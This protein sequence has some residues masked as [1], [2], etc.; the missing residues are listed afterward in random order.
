MK[1]YLLDMGK[2]GLEYLETIELRDYTDDDIKKLTNAFSVELIAPS[3]PFI[4]FERENI[5][6]LLSLS[7]CKRCGKC[8]LPDKT[9]P[10]NPG[11]IVGE[12]DLM[13]I[14]K[15]TKHSLKSLK[16]IV[17]LS[18]NPKYHAGALFL[19]LP[20]M[21]FNKNERSCKIYSHRPLICRIYPISDDS[22][23]DNVTIDV[24]CDYGKEI[25]QKALKL[26][27]DADR[28]RKKVV[29]GKSGELPVL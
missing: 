5:N 3:V 23:A 25:F 7:K 13:E 6:K 17:R 28:R 29:D 12:S 4:L 1:K 19:P 21:F 24:H 8:C 11:V 26:L 20:C 16:K 15:N 18:E 27:R 2:Y 14:S 10:D 22:G 9:A